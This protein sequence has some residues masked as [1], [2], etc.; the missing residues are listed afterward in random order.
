MHFIVLDRE[1]RPDTKDDEIVFLLR[2][3]TFSSRKHL[4]EL[5]RILVWITIDHSVVINGRKRPPDQFI[6]VD[7][8]EKKGR[9]NGNAVLMKI[10]L[11]RRHFFEL[12]GSRPF[13]NR[14]VNGDAAIEDRHSHFF[15]NGRLLR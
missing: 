6:R 11:R 3:N 1:P 2:E 9:G 10:G 13:G 5:K 7:M 15:R 8:A 4:E 14:M 12:I